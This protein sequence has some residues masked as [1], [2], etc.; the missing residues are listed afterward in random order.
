MSAFG[1]LRKQP[2]RGPAL[3]ARLNDLCGEVR[4]STG[5]PEALK[6]IGEFLA[7]QQMEHHSH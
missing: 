7:A 3:Y 6:A 4:I 5:D 2:R 1:G